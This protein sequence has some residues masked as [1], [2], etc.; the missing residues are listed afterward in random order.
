[1]ARMTALNLL[2]Q[3]VDGI[4]NANAF[5]KDESIAVFE[6]KLA[7]YQ[8]ENLQLQ[9]RLELLQEELVEAKA[10]NLR[11]RLIV[12]TQSETIT[13]LSWQANPF[14]CDGEP[15]CNTTWFPE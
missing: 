13:E 5:D 8:A 14:S 15:L 10:E 2:R 1:M 7:K 4:E 9:E 11:L 3:C 12:N 6:Q